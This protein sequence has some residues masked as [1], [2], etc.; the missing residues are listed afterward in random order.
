MVEPLGTSVF[1][2]SFAEAMPDSLRQTVLRWWPSTGAGSRVK[3]WEWL[4]LNTASPD[5]RV[6]GD[7]YDTFPPN[8]S[9]WFQVL[10]RL[11]ASEDVAKAAAQFEEVHSPDQDLWHE[12]LLSTI[13]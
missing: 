6:F 4:R 5:D 2:Y 7:E 9:D 10:E 1:P 3:D 12:L 13:R 8:F 11:C